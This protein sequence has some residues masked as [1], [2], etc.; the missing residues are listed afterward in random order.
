VA[1]GAEVA[2]VTLRNNQGDSNEVFLI[3]PQEFMNN[4]GRSIASFVRYREIKP[5]NLV[6]I[7]DEV[8]IPFET[9]RVKLGG[10]N[11]GHNGIKSTSAHLGTGDFFRLRL[12]VGR[13]AHPDF[14]LA[15]WVLSNFSNEESRRLDDFLDRASNSLISLLQDGLAKTQA[16][17]NS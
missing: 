13:P 1:D 3:K 10:G 9:M 6:V 7:H 14:D 17:F 4:S 15:D 16:K 8:E 5:S 12:G 11:A 2:S